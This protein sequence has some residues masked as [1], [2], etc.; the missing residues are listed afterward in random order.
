MAFHASQ[1]ADIDKDLLN[2]IQDDFPLTARPYQ[3]VGERLGITE[4]EAIERTAVMKNQHKVIRQISPIFDT[5]AL[6]YQSALVAMKIP[7]ERLLAS[8]KIVNEHPGVSHN[9]Q[10]SHPF[11]MWF[12]VAVAPGSRLGVQGTIDALHQLAG[13]ERTI[14]LPTLRLFKIG[15]KLDLTGKSLLE[16]SSGDHFSEKDREKSA[17]LRLS[18][19]DVELVKVMQVDL[20]VVAEPYRERAEILEITQDELFERLLRMKEKAQLR[21]VAAILYHRRAGFRENVMGVWKVPAEDVMRVGPMMAQYA[22]VSH[23]YERPVY[24]PDWEYSIYTMVHGQNREECE[25]ILKAMQQE[26][27]VA[28]MLPLRSEAEFKKIRLLYFTEDYAGWEE[29]AMAQLGQK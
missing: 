9:Y 14:E 7:P 21:R 12:T 4:E 1:L 15:M 6:G 5:R 20:P 28:E 11:N 16:K 19:S 18:E 26:T 25:A 3:V 13:A 2:A 23:C 29:K 24:P 8:A 10:R 22:T 27:G 17:G